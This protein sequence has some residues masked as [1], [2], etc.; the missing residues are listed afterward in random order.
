MTR[1]DHYPAG[2]PCF[3]EAFSPD[4][5]AARR[6]YAGIFGWEFG[7]PGQMPSDPPGEYWIA[8]AR[9][10][11]V[12]G[13]GSLPSPQTPVAW[14]TQVAVEDADTVARRARDAGGAVLVEP[15]DAPPADRTVY[16]LTP[17]GRALEPVLHALGRWGSDVELGG[18][19]PPLSPDAAVVAMQT[20]YGPGP[21]PP[22]GAV[23][24]RLDG[25]EFELRPGAQRLAAAAGSSAAPQA[26]METDS[27]TLAAVLWHG[28]DLDRAIA[29]R[30]VTI[31]GDERLVRTLIE[32]Y[33]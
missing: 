2:V 32:R 5:D 25:H 19:P 8:R 10:A 18:A 31:D 22:R 6:F 16:D 13:L 7:G 24:M 30:R 33:R 27:G 4:L 21:R 26:T 11:E 20:M 12:A 29:D 3:V 15:V 9:G 28:L 17:R 14:H 23:A 1:F